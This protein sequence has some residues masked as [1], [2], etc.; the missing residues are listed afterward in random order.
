MDLA[1]EYNNRDRVPEHPRIIAGWYADAKTYRDEVP[2]EADI[3]YAAR[4]RNRVDLF[5]APGGRND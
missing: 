2:V 5:A 3:A 1:A 4:P